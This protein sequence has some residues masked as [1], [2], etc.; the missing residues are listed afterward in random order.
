MNN[1]NGRVNASNHEKKIL[2]AALLLAVALL[3]VFISFVINK[4]TEGGAN[5]GTTDGS[6]TSPEHSSNSSYIESTASSSVAET[7]PD[8]PVVIDPFAKYTDSSVEFG[9]EYTFGNGIL[10][11]LKINEVIASRAAEEI[12]YPASLTKIMTL[13]VAVENCDDMT[14]TYTFTDED[15][16]FFFEQQA[17]TAGYVAGE[18]GNVKD[19][20]YGLMLP[21]GADCAV[22]LAHVIAGGE[23]AFVEMMNEKAEAL[24]LKNTHFTNMTGLH[25]DDHYSTCHELAVIMKYALSNDFMR[26]VMQ[27]YQYTTAPTSEHPEGMLLTSSVFSR[28]YGNEPQNAFVL[29]GKTGFTFEAKYC[30]ATFGVNCSEEDTEEHI[31]SLDPDMILIIVNTPDRW[32]TIFHTIDVYSEFA[33]KQ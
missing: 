9:D 26:E 8:A 10:I 28:M 32:S 30:L 3:L 27:T 25:D 31:Y 4:G 16:N 12:I 1:R 20:I 29:G 14:K 18:S 21:S 13:I 22:G 24:S 23:D 5:G 6:S 17:S 11:D 19:M 33:V 15:I 7:E 2:V